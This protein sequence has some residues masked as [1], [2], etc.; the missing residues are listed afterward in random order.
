[1]GGGCHF[2]ITLQFK[3]ICFV[4]EESKVP[5]I[6]FWIFSI[7]SEPFKTLIHVFIVLKLGIIC[8][9]LIYSGSLQKLL[10]GLFNLL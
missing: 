6:T 2:F 4:C 8:T 3:H 9:V 7:L 5:F 10:T 1:M